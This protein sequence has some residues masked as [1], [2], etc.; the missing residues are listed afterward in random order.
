[1]TIRL[2]LNT[3]KSWSDAQSSFWSWPSAWSSL[4]LLH[5][6]T[7]DDDRVEDGGEAITTT[8]VVLT[9]DGALVETDGC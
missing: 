4:L 1:L 7:G 6:D 2:V 3:V 5:D 8:A 9:G